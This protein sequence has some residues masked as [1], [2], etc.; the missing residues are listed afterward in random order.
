MS[1][2]VEGCISTSGS[3]SLRIESVTATRVG[4][5]GLSILRRCTSRVVVE[6]LAAVEDF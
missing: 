5:G 2:E 4:E 3:G 6:L 1:V